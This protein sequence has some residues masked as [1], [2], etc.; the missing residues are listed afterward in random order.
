MNHARKPKRFRLE[1]HL[2]EDNFKVKPNDTCQDTHLN[3]PL[4]NVGLDNA[5]KDLTGKTPFTQLPHNRVVNAYDVRRIMEAAQININTLPSLLKNPQCLLQRLNNVGLY[6]PNLPFDHTDLVKH[7]QV[8]SHLTDLTGHQF[9]PENALALV[10]KLVTPAS[11]VPNWSLIKRY[12]SLRSRLEQ[13]V[14]LTAKPGRHNLQL[15]LLAYLGWRVVNLTGTKR[16]GTVFYTVVDGFGTIYLTSR[17]CLIV[18]EFGTWISTR[19]HFLMLHDCI[20]QRWICLYAVS[21]AKMLGLP[22]YPSAETILTVWDWGDTLLNYFGNEAYNAI[23]LWESLIYGLIMASEVDPVVDSELFLRN[24][25]EELFKS[26]ACDDGMTRR[27]WERLRDE[28]LLSQNL[29]QLSQLHGFYRIW[30]HPSI[31]LI[32]GLANLRQVA[33]TLRL[34]CATSIHYQLMSWREQ[35]CTGYY[36]KEHKWPQMT[37]LPS[38]PSSSLVGKCLSSGTP[39]PLNSPQYSLDDWEHIRF[40]KTFSVPAK[41]DLNT[42]TKDSATSLGFEELKKN[43][44]SRGTIGSSAERS[45]IIRYLAKN[46][47]SPVDFLSKIDK[48]GFDPDEK[49]I[50]LREKE[51]EVSIKGRYF[52]LLPIEKRIYVVVSE[53]MIAE[54][55][56]NY[57]PEITMTYNQVKLREHIQRATQ[58]L[59]TSEENTTTVVTNMDFVKWNSN[60][61]EAETN[62]LFEDIDHLFGFTRVVSRTYEMFEQSQMYLA[63]GHI[64]P[65]LSDCGKK[66]KDGPTVW[67]NHLGGVEGL[68][69]KGWTVFTVSLIKKVARMFGLNCTLMGQGDNQV[70]VTTYVNRAEKS[71]KDQ[72]KDFIRV[73]TKCLSSIGPPLKPEETWSS[74]NFFTYGKYA[75]WKG[76]PLTLAMKLLMKMARMTNEGLQNL[77]STLSSM[78]A[79]CTAATEADTSPL[80]AYLICALECSVATEIS[81][82]R[83]F[84]SNTSNLDVKKTA[85]FRLPQSKVSML[86]PVGKDERIMDQLKG[87]TVDGLLM[88]LIAPSSLG[89]YPVSHYWSYQMHG[90]PD[91]LSLDI[92]GLKSAYSRTNKP[93]LKVVI[94]RLL[95]P[96]F[97]PEINPVMLCEDPY[98][99]NL[100]H[101]STSVDKVKGMVLKFLIEA[102]ASFV[103]NV[104]FL[105]FLKLAVADQDRLGELL[106]SCDHLHPRICNAVMESTIVGKVNQALSKITKTGVLIRIMMANRFEGLN[107][108]AAR[109]SMQL[110]TADTP[111]DDMAL[112]PTTQKT[113]FELFGNFEQNQFNCLLHTINVNSSPVPVSDIS[114]LCSYVHARKLRDTSW[115]KPVEGVTVAVPWE[116]LTVSRSDNANCD[117]DNH[118]L[119]EAGYVLTTVIGTVDVD[120]AVGALGHVS[121]GPMTPYLGKGTKNKVDYEAKQ[122]AE[123]SPAILRSALA[124]LQLVGW[125]V[126]RESKFAELIYQI[127]ESVTDAPARHMAPLPDEI[128]GT[129]GHRYDDVKTARMCTSSI[130][131]TGSS[132]IV[133]NT[134]HFSPEKVRTDI[135]TD[136]LHIHFQSIFLFIQHHFSVH[137]LFYGQPRESQSYHWHVNC[138]DCVYPVYEQT[139]EL[140]EENIDWTEFQFLEKQ[141]ENPYLWV[142]VAALPRQLLPKDDWGFVDAV[143]EDDSYELVEDLLS[144]ALVSDLMTHHGL[145][146]PAFR[147]QPGVETKQYEIPVTIVTKLKI[148]PFVRELIYNLFLRLCWI[149][150]TRLD[151]HEQYQNVL[152]WVAGHLN[153]LRQIPLPWFD[154]L[155][156]LLDNPS[157]L[158]SALRC[159]KTLNAPIGSPPSKGQSSFFF[160]EMFRLEINDPEFI[161]RFKYWCHP[162]RNLNRLQI[163]QHGLSNHPTSKWAMS[164]LLHGNCDDRIW[165]FVKYLKQESLLYTDVKITSVSDLTTL[166]V[167]DNIQKT[168]LDAVSVSFAMAR[169]KKLNPNPRYIAGTHHGISAA[170][171][172]RVRPELM[173]VSA[174]GVADQPLIPPS[175]SGCVSLAHITG[176]VLNDTSSVLAE[177]ILPDWEQSNIVHLFKPFK[178]PTTA[179]YKL[180]SLISHCLA[181]GVELPTN[182]NE[183]LFGVADGDGGFCQIMHRLWPHKEIVYNSLYDVTK[184]SPSGASSVRPSSIFGSESLIR[185]VLGLSLVEEGLSDLT[186]PNT[187]SALVANFKSGE[188]LV[189]DAEGE[190][191][192]NPDKE[193]NLASHVS[194]L[195]HTLKCKTVIYK[196]YGKSVGLCYSIINIWL[197]YYDSIEIVRS[198]FSGFGNTEIYL[199]ITKPLKDWVRF[200]R[201]HVTQ[202]GLGFDISSYRSNISFSKFCRLINRP[203]VFLTT[204]HKISCRYTDSLI[205]FEL[206][207]MWTQD[208]N[209]FIFR[210]SGGYKFQF[211]LSFVKSLNQQFAPVTL[212]R[213]TPATWVISYFTP[214]V[215]TEIFT[216]FALCWGLS[217]LEAGESP[218][219]WANWANSVKLF[220]LLCYQTVEGKWSFWPVLEHEVWPPLSAAILIRSSDISEAARKNLISTMGKYRHSSAGM[221]RSLMK[222]GFCEGWPS[223]DFDKHRLNN[224]TVKRVLPVRD[225]PTWLFPWRMAPVPSVEWLQKEIP[226]NW[227]YPEVD[228]DNRVSI[229]E[230]YHTL[231]NWDKQPPE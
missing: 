37:I 71:I 196:T 146:S 226:D 49:V 28:V 137:N 125:A 148:V 76:G 181:T 145:L 134:N 158:S 149:H 26:V 166:A 95:F 29:H 178:N 110:E 198:P 61:R 18:T 25:E 223:W 103:Q 58:K 33:C 46:W 97:N 54:E 171:S 42:T 170:L 122:L 92:Q 200:P 15:D 79:N 99:L 185:K 108:V 220:S 51:R 94:H 152:P 208:L 174:Q 140:G 72:H 78:T 77:S 63:N 59:K 52:G 114:T 161:E 159:W 4:H 39:L 88:I 91:Q 127:I 22:N 211:P 195:C 118:P 222:R 206:K 14:I 221:N 112:T 183:K 193:I 36:N 102:G 197:S 7:I 20:A 80:I 165:Y 47:T 32:D 154:P 65:E 132:Y 194:K 218:L 23:K 188:M 117:I 83:P 199:I 104:H 229:R 31:D 93:L 45:V 30:G 191:I 164:T 227:F 107:T 34:Q 11:T 74:S 9:I 192:S 35:F 138:K 68:R 60:M 202:N 217:I 187:V 162:R 111:H 62:N 172:P 213:S 115:G 215:K 50:G 131:P 55:L 86:F 136:N 44:E 109:S 2:D 209:N 133:S 41:F 119:S 38:M 10:N 96:P 98:S 169:F 204:P 231:L 17:H 142:S 141:P 150:A 84:F 120:N 5:I 40:E 190:G 230:H 90:F 126:E 1:A 121:L 105:D 173:E 214:A 21:L 64:L 67:S 66:L 176:T 27:K 182:N 70:L 53:A 225:R 100:L 16:G 3:N 85:G 175:E 82:S 48:E 180:L 19:D 153:T 143:S 106:Y 87:M 13:G 8:S 75:V 224:G 219:L 101:G 163:L 155:H 189:C 157:S 216:H 57:F 168:H 186:K 228:S 89:G 147:G 81:L 212:S 113:F 207:R 73:L 156:R 135:G 205:S 130:I 43:L 129:Y 24:M 124:L 69:Q 56:L 210:Y 184:M 144:Q 116:L 167:P 128:A 160:Q 179:P 139:I 6:G 151:Y 123:Q 201:I 203:E 177:R 12:H